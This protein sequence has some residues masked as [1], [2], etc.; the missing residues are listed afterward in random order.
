MLISFWRCKAPLLAFH[1]GDAKQF[2][3]TARFRACVD[4]QLLAFRQARGE[5]ASEV[6]FAVV[7]ASAAG[8]LALEFADIVGKAFDRH[9]KRGRALSIV[10]VLN[11]LRA[12]Y[13]IIP[14]RL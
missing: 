1:L 12:H 11:L 9:A 2:G 3:L 4:A 5:Y 13:W 6:G 10:F 14:K 7:C 8:E